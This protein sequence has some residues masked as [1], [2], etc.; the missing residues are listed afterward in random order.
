MVNLFSRIEAIN[1]Q[2]DNNDSSVTDGN[3]PQMDEEIDQD[4]TQETL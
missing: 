3:E 1:K 4:T 2:S